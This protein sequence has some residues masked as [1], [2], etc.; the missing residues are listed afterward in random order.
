MDTDETMMTISFIHRT[1]LTSEIVTRFLVRRSTSAAACCEK[2]LHLLG[3][4][5]QVNA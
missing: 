3:V 2:S 4:Y 5:G 1:P